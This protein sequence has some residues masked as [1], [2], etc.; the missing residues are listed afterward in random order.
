MSVLPQ[1]LYDDII[2]LCDPRS[3]VSCGLVCRSWVP[4]SRIKLFANLR[5]LIISPSSLSQVLLLVDSPAS[6]ISPYITSIVLKD[7]VHAAV[8][9][10]SVSFYAI[11][12]RITGRMVAVESLAFH[13]TDWEEMADGA[14]KFLV[15]AF[16]DTLKTLELRDCSCGTFGSLVSL[17][18]SFSA[19]ENLSLH[20]LVRLNPKG[21][22]LAGS[23]PPSLDCL[24]SIYAHGYIKK[25]LFQWIMSTKRVGIEVVTVG[26]LLPGEARAVGKFLKSL[27]SN[28]KHITL[29]G[30][31]TPNLHRDIDLKHN[32]QLTSIHFTNLMLHQ[33]GSEGLDWFIRMLLPMQSPSLRSLQFSFCVHSKGVGTLEAIDWLA[34]RFS[35][36]M[37]QHKEVK[38]WWVGYQE[39]AEKFVRER[40]PQYHDTGIL[41]CDFEDS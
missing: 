36:C 41:C 39:M 3:L 20:R 5:P 37:S 28:L 29:S 34:L 32:G 40:L 15:F 27:K 23:P 12:P 10:G 9:S 13:S 21:M 22:E 38:G 18:C 31:S 26:P 25:E 35:F 7:W 2:S 6:T 4:S 33:H 17:A 14:L 24:R 11:L 16:K 19:L 8:L 1:E 30:E